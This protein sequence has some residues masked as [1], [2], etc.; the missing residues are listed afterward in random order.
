MYETPLR[1][2]PSL[3]PASASVCVVLPVRNEAES[4]GYALDSVLAQTFPRART[5]IVVVDGLSEDGTA[6]LVKERMNGGANLRLLSNPRRLTSPALNIGIRSTDADIVVRVDGHC[7]LGTEYIE[8]CVRLLAESGAANV[9]GLMRPRATGPVGRAMSIALSSPF[10]I[11]DSRFHYL[12]RRAYVDSVYLGAFRR[13]ILTEVGGFNETLRANEDFELNHRIR[14]AGYGVLLSPDIEST[15]TPRG[16]IPSI[17]RQFFRYGRNKA[18]VMIEH[19]ESI[20]ARHVAPPL[21][22]G[23]LLVSAAAAGVWRNK[24][25]LAPV[26]GYGAS[27]AVA[28]FVTAKPKRLA[29][30]LSLVFPSM[31]LSWG[32]GVLVGILGPGSQ[33]RFPERLPGRGGMRW[34]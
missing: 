25:L 33:R 4:I 1:R 10:G 13:E 3:D 14:S 16:T 9:G 22:V 28:A 26:V 31:H 21:V 30:Q 5:E 27:V 17:C 20:Q 24:L 34:N 23:T 7:R 6:E 12:E 18:R 15:Y 11:G 32:M 2:A 19:P 8:R 29:A